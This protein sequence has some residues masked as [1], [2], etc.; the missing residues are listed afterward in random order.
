MCVGCAPIY[1]NKNINISSTPK[2]KFGPLFYKRPHY[3]KH[4]IEIKSGFSA[5]EK[6]KKHLHSPTRDTKAIVFTENAIYLTQT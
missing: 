5:T 3:Y 2:K 1:T 4:C 6:K